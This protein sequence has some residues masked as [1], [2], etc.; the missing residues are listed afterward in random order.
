M[1]GLITGDHVYSEMLLNARVDV[2]N[3]EVI[4]CQCHKQ[5]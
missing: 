4:Y 2:R 3:D 1:P 5:Y